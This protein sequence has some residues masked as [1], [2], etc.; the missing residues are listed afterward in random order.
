M[1]ARTT[2]QAARAQIRAAFEKAWDRV[3]TT[4]LEERAA[5]EDTAQLEPGAL[6][7][8]PDC[9]SA[10]LYLQRSEPANRTIR[11]T[12]GEAVRGQQGVRCRACDG[13]FSPSGA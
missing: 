9:G 8:C 4:L 1:A 7:R 6:G 5:L 10:G 11:T 13:S 12:H 3:I 2:R